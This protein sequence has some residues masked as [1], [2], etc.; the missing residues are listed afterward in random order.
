MSVDLVSLLSLVNQAD[1]DSYVFLNGSSR[2][3]DE[4]LFTLNLSS[5]SDPKSDIFGV[6]PDL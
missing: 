3:V 4:L 5:Y 1:Y 2:F 6:P